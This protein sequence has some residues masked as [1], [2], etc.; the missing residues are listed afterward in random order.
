M[1]HSAYGPSMSL[2]RTAG[3]AEWLLSDWYTGRN[4][5]LLPELQSFC[6]ACADRGYYY[7]FNKVIVINL[8]APRGLIQAIGV[9]PDGFIDL[10]WLI[11]AVYKPQF[12][13]F[14][15]RVAAS[16]E[17]AAVHE[18]KAS[19]NVRFKDRRIILPEF[20]AAAG[21]VLD[22]LADLKRRVGA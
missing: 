11:P 7:K 10:P 8:R 6:D 5:A 15:E 3:P 18:S 12:R 17:G 2:R 21:D 13:V 1:L 19:W 16:V 4:E 14:A 22:A 9:E 20:L